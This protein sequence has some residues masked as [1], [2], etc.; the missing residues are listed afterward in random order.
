MSPSVMALGHGSFMEA[1][2][3][4]IRPTDTRRIPP[5]PPFAS[6]DPDSTHSRPPSLAFC[7]QEIAGSSPV[8]S[9]V[10]TACK[11]ASL[12]GLGT[13]AAR[14]PHYPPRPPRETHRTTDAR[15]VGD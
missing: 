12:V 1:T 13:Y 14:R 2:A 5:V 3:A 11:H 7:K 4:R 8:G 9:I 6:P 15:G 10:E